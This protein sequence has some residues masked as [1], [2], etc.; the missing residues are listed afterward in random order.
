MHISY[1]R[2]YESELGIQRTDFEVP[3]RPREEW[4]FDTLPHGR[5]VHVHP[6]PLVKGNKLQRIKS[7]NENCHI[8]AN[9]FLI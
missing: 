6:R 8:L 1:L 7:K 9:I 2:K 5:I 4:Y 3:E